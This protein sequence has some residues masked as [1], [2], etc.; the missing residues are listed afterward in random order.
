M[1]VMA[2]EAHP[3]DVEHLCAGTLAKYRAAGHDVAI[4]C[5]TNGELGSPDAGKAETAA[6]REAE[7]RRAASLIAAEFFWLG[8]PDA[9]LFSTPEV[10]LHVIDT[11]RR[12]R[13]D[14]II[15]LDKDHDYHPDHTLTGQLVWDAHILLTVPNIETGTPA[16]EAIPDLFFMDTTAGIAFD[17]EVYVDITDFWPTK[18]AMLECHESQ[19][20]WCR[21]QYGAPLA[22]SAEAQSR[23]R[24]YQSG[25][26]YAEAFRQ[27]RCFPQ[28][29]RPDGLLPGGG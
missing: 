26:R 29:T 1:R 10:R 12:F 4:A 28:R 6:T 24:G 3:D 20:R 27:P 23:F 7:A 21:D 19:D 11:I 14:L 22:A 8:Y 18:L 17:P 13:P 16:C 15:T 5:L 9:F 25:C 2:I